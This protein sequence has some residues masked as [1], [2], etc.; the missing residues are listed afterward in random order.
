MDINLLLAQFEE[1]KAISDVHLCTGEYITYRK[2]GEIIFLEEKPK[3]TTTEMEEYV[4][5]LLASHPDG[6][7]K[8]DANREIDFNFYS[9]NG[10]PYRINAYYTLEKL[11]VAMRKISYKPLPLETIMYDDIANAVKEHILHQKT[12]LFLVT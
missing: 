11:A 12:G 6:R 7:A 4:N 10:V 1:D 9:T 3:V 2:V 5:Q 8:L